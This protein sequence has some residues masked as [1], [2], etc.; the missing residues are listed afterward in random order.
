MRRCRKLQGR[1]L[2]YRYCQAHDKC[3]NGLGQTLELAGWW[4]RRLGPHV[5]WQAVSSKG[6]QPWRWRLDAVRAA[7]CVLLDVSLGQQAKI[8]RRLAFG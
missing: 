8:N 7:L 6:T 3:R 5:W 4:T 1:R 2:L